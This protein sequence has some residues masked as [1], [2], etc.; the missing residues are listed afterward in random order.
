MRFIGSKVLLL[1]K[2][3]KIIEENIK[4]NAKP[5]CDIF[6]GTSSVARYFK[7]KYEVYS[8]DIM[9]FSY[10]LQKSTIENDKIPCFYKLQQIGIDDPINYLENIDIRDIDFT[11]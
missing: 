5:F 6:S 9:N 4:D 3:N 1:D 7:Y 10:V 8:N 2:I 11:D